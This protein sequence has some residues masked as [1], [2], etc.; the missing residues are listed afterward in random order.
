MKILGFYSEKEPSEVEII[1]WLKKGVALNAVTM[2]IRHKISGLINEKD[3][4]PIYIF[5]DD[6]LESIR[7]ECNSNWKRIKKEYSIIEMQNNKEYAHL[8]KTDYTKMK[9]IYSSFNVLFEIKEF[10]D[11]KYH[12]R[13]AIPFKNQNL[14]LWFNEYEEF[15]SQEIVERIL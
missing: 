2:I 9:E 8:L 6:D 1:E 3:F 13:I 4:E 12:K 10:E 11:K 15:V 14:E 5:K 7:E